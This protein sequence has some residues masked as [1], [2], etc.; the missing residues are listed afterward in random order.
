MQADI[1]ALTKL[2][3]DYLASVQGA[4]VRRFEELLADDFLCT[5]PDG[6][7]YNRAQFLELIGKGARIS[8]LREDQV[9]IGLFGDFAIIHARIHYRWIAGVELEGR[10]TDD[11]TRRDGIWLCV[12]AHTS[13]EDF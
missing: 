10:V 2:N 8:E 3:H 6:A 7:L 12:S 5:N 4:S 11:W 1:D 9:N 13:V